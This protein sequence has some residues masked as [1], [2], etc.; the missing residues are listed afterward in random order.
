M[1]CD[2]RVFICCI[3]VKK[4]FYAT[5]VFKY[6]TLV[7]TVMDEEKFEQ[8]MEAIQTTQ[9]DLKADVLPKSRN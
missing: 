1:S 4:S 5:C 7:D 9:K 3:C 8:L 6:A 2:R